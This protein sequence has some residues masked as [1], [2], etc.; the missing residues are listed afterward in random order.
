[1]SPLPI[2]TALKEGAHRSHLEGLKQKDME[3]YLKHYLEIAGIKEEL[4]YEEAILTIHQGLGRTPAKG[5]PSCKGFAHY[6]SARESN[7]RIG[8]APGWHRQRYFSHDNQV[9][10]CR[11]PLWSNHC[12]KED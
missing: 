4:F 12:H 2:T 1:M 10:E 8:R 5:Q 7:G 3:G 11:Y 6:S 9:G